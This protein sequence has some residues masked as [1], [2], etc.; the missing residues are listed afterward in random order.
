MRDQSA[1][2]DDYRAL[3]ETVDAWFAR[4]LETAGRHIHCRPGCSGCCRGLFDI[5]LMDAAL[6]R[7]G[8]ELLPET[9]R[10]AA[11]TKSRARLSELQERWPGFG[12][13][14]LLN[15]LPD[16]EWTEM[17]EEDATPCP[18]LGE[19]GRCLVYAFRPMTCRLHGLPNI[20]R[21]GESFSDT[22]CTLNFTAVDPLALP[23][24]RWNFRRAFEAELNLF[25]EFTYS[26]LGAPRKELD[27]FIPLALLMDFATLPGSCGGALSR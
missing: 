2:L 18:L 23:E 17:P 16:A 12:P 7:R 25:G 1:I 24:L 22:W 3:L 10:A 13:P 20:D 9:V 14:Y 8:F 15:H 21:S 6:L 11:L 5:T 4:C 19:D 27:T 26:L